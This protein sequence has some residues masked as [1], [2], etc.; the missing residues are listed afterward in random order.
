MNNCCISWVFTHMLKKFTVQE[1]KSPEKNF[2]RQRCAEGFNSGVK[3]LKKWTI[4]RPTWSDCGY[5]QIMAVLKSNVLL[6]F[7][8]HSFPNF[9][10][11]S[12]C[13]SNSRTS[14]W[15]QELMSK[16]LANLFFNL[17][18]PLPASLCLVLYS[19]LCSF[20]T[21][22]HFVYMFPAHL[23]FQLLPLRYNNLCLQSVFIFSQSYS[24]RGGRVTQSV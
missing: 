24:L 23:I 19:L 16:S 10:F 21:S 20:S 1:A 15:K 7:S 8:S 3:G 22:L 13:S 4:H 17:L 12:Y 18:L 14:F 2:F 5:C 11:S 6:G 9:Y